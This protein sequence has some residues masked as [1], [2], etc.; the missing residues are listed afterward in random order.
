MFDSELFS[1]ISRKAPDVVLF[2]QLALL[3]LGFT[4]T[5]EKMLHEPPTTSLNSQETFATNLGMDNLSSQEEDLMWIHAGGVANLEYSSESQTPCE[6]DVV[7]MWGHGEGVEEQH[8]YCV[9]G[10]HPVHI[11]EL[12]SSCPNA[13]DRGRYRI[14]HK[15]GGGVF[16]TVWF[17]QD[18]SLPK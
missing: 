9:G 6:D 5:P 10:L 18:M 13:P 3:H 14:L 4:V 11:N 17:A 12:Y 7:F 15:L 1:I 16:S 2:W 8:S